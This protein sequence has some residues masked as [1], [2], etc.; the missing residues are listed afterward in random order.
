MRQFNGAVAV[1]SMHMYAAI[2]HA[3]ESRWLLTAT[4]IVVRLI[5]QQQLMDCNE[6]TRDASA[7]IFKEIEMEMK[8][9]TNSQLK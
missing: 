2:F 1:F 5:L 7:V 6:K 9:K 3:T 8:T 4:Q